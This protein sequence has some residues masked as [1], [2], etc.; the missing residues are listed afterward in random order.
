MPAD[1][2]HHDARRRARRAFS[3]RTAGYAVAGAVLACVI[4]LVAWSV[5]TAPGHAPEE[6]LDAPPAPT[7]ADRPAVDPENIQDV[8][9]GADEGRIELVDERNRVVQ[10]L[11]YDEFTPQEAGRFLVTK[12]RAWLYLERGR[13]VVIDADTLN[14]SQQRAGQ[15][16]ESGRFSGS[17]R[18]RI[19]D[20]AGGEQHRA[21]RGDGD[22]DA[23]APEPDP[24]LTLSTDALVFDTAIGE[25]GAPGLVEITA[26]GLLARFEGLD[27]LVDQ[28]GRRLAL[29]RTERDGFVRITPADL[30][31]AQTTP[32]EPGD[33]AA[34]PDAAPAIDFYRAEFDSG[35]RVAMGGRTLAADRL[36]LWARL[37][38]GAIPDGAI[39]G[40]D[41]PAT[42]SA[43][44]D[45]PREADAGP[46][47]IE[48]ITIAWAGALTVR[49]EAQQPQTLA[50]DDLAMRF[51]APTSG[52]VEIDDRQTGAS[53][54]A[55]TLDYGLTTR[56]LALTGVGETGVS[57]RV[58][59]DAE[60]LAGRLEL[61]LTTGVG[62]VPGPGVL[63]SL[64]EERER[65]R[66]RIT[67]RER[68]DFILATA[69][70]LVDLRAA[71]PVE[72]A[73]FTGA[74][75]AR[76]GDA[77]V[78]GEFIRAELATTPA[79]E[80][81]I[82]R[83]IVEGDAAADAGDDGS[84]LARRV[85]VEFDTLAA[86][87]TPTLVTAEGAVRAEREGASLE[88]E[89]VE[90]TVVRLDDGELAVSDL[91][92]DLGVLVRTPEGAELSGDEL[93]AKVQE[94]IFD[95]TGQPAIL[96]QDNAA[97]TGE[98]MR[99]EADAERLTVFGPGVLNYARP[100]RQGAGYERAQVEWSGSMRYDGALD[101][102]EFSGTCVATAE[103]DAFSRDR[104]TAERILVTLTPDTQP[105]P[106]AGGAVADAQ[107]AIERVLL[108]GAAEEGTGDAPVQVE[109][110]QY[111]RDADADTGLRLES[112]VFLESRAIDA[113]IADNDLIVPHPGRL[114]LENRREGEPA[115][116]EDA[117]SVFDVRGSTLFEWEGDLVFDRDTGSAVMSR[118]VRLRQL[119]PGGEEMTELECERLT[120]RMSLPD[121]PDQPA[122]L[123]SAEASG[124]VYVR[125]ATRQLI[126][127]RLLYDASTGVAEATAALGNAV[128]L[129]DANNP[130]PLTGSLLR[131][132]LVR[133]RLEWRDA[134]AATTPR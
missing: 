116:D 105:A 5:A 40:F 120:A 82:A 85:E 67:W 24:A 74:A 114:L 37:V 30:Q 91:R 7:I 62:A 90:A 69:G 64:A 38:G 99:I 83:V 131:W 130:T 125:R 12:P 47:A 97:I 17:V 16:P 25:L 98:S 107:G 118:Q 20:A 58:P 134:G 72:E 96:R 19:Y 76:Y 48:E 11:F 60:L 3:T 89:L 13:T 115:P 33:Q 102:V 45:A 53:A 27:L 73:I 77:F 46:E 59:G 36:D 128:T 44:P 113:R 78:T 49:P 23:H 1:R 87:P 127:D 31:R 126:A 122:E 56:R 106:R 92:A 112:V 119:P 51:T 70:G 94:G 101:E 95:V 65:Q 34:A 108:F 111:V 133:D 124:A 132:D 15:E 29:L 14:F 2:P 121:D 84:L 10:E 54:R 110:R 32:G 81:T 39:A 26:P 109:S 61:N 71:S 22:A 50:Q 63:R 104:A 80:P 86:E 123:R 117:A 79:G 18:V 6:P 35:V 4:G 88:G 129:F 41:Q 21:P 68:S 100:S 103:L 43:E 55:A 93:R 52:L 9:A 57:V 28:R 8:I 66:Q 75:E 42:D